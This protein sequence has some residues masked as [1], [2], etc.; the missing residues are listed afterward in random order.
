MLFF[1]WGTKIKSWVVDNEHQ[2]VAHWSYFSIF[3]CPIAFGITWHIRGDSR[4]EDKMISHNDV[5]RMF[6][7]ATPDIGMWNR[8][9]LLIIIGGLFL[10]SLFSK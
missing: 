4:L 7:V 9:G 5:K 6:P 2:L 3:F 1:G 8:C 10:L